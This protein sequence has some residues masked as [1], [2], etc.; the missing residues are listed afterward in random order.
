MRARTSRSNAK[1][2][3]HPQGSLKESSS[4]IAETSTPKNR[5]FFYEPDLHLTQTCQNHL[6]ASAGTIFG[7]SY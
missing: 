6:E 3:N 4:P 7:A 1:P 2:S 5:K